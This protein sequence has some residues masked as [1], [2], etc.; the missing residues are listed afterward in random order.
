M[1]SARAE[2]G[3]PAR[4]RMLA[5]PAN[6]NESGSGG[7]IVRFRARFGIARSPSGRFGCC[8]CFGRGL[9]EP[10]APLLRSGCGLL[11][12]AAIAGWALGPRDPPP[13]PLD[14]LSGS[15]AL[16]AWLLGHGC[17]R[18]HL[19][20]CGSSGRRLKLSH[21]DRD[22]V[23]DV[24]EPYAG[25]DNDVGDVLALAPE[26]GGNVVGEVLDYARDWVAAQADGA[27]L[28]AGEEDHQATAS[29]VALRAGHRR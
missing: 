22:Q 26:E 4:S 19:S 6:G 13:A 29:S 24:V 28:I 12:A 20:G 9:R 27:D 2:A 18:F 21:G 15:A 25:R 14:L 11:L 7:T 23:A 5:T 16:G 17:S 8:C 1:E 10:Q 3:R